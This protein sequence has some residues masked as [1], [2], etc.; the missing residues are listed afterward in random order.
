[1]FVTACE[2]WRT[3][4]VAVATETVESETLTTSGAVDSTL[5]DSQ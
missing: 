2:S 1:V 3:T 4:D 5:A